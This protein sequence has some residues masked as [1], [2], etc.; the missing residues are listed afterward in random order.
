MAP[1][2][3]NAGPAPPP[4]RASDGVFLDL[5]G[6][7][8]EL[9][10]RPK[11]IRADAGLA[12]LLRDCAARLGN[13]LAIVSG[14]PIA[15][16]DYCLAPDRHLSS[17]LHGLERRGAA[18]VVTVRPSGD[19]GVAGIASTLTAAIAGLAGTE[20]EDKGRALALHWRRAPQ[21]ADA[22]RRLAADAAREL[23][24]DWRLLEGSCVVELLPRAATKGTA[25]RA[26]MREMPFAGRRPVYVGDD[27]T[28]V[29]GFEAVREFGGHGIAVGD[30][31][32]AEYGLADVP[33]VRR[34][35]AELAK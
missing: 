19:A 35:L 6:T 24:P 32:P 30:R 7:L 9:R 11:G 2:H 18:G 16:L 20:L 3:R 21:H 1:T 13:A 12:M 26:F 29:D 31:V 23:G 5:D 15:E 25:V 27:L 34:W 4:L 17:G 10:T 22:L 28:D 33:A 8:L 14:R